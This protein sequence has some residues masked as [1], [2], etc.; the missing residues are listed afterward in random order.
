MKYIIVKLEPYE[1]DD[2]VLSTIDLDGPTGIETDK[3]MW[4]IVEIDDAG[5]VADVDYGYWSEQAAKDA[6]L[7]STSHAPWMRPAGQPR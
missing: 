1:G 5:T 2:S 7:A 3:P 4:I 6:V